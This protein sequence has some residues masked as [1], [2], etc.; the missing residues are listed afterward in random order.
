[1]KVETEARPTP[2]PR[3]RPWVARPRRF[4]RSYRSLVS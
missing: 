3:P 4:S 1:M 2:R